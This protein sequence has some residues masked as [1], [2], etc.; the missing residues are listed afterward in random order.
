MDDQHIENIAKLISESILA[1]SL[2]I[3]QLIIDESIKITHE[4]STKET[5]LTKIIIAESIKE[6]II[7]R[8][9]KT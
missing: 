1:N 4:I 2:K 8:R 6:S 9:N 3:T 5:D 7:K